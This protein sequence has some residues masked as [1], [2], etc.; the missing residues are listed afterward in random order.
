MS[1][2]SAGSLLRGKRVLI[3]A[4]ATR[5][6]LDPVR[7]LTNASTGRMGFALAEAARESGA[8]VTVVA[9][10]TDVPPPSGVRVVRVE[11]AR[12]MHRA[13]LK[14][15]GACDVF[16]GA[17]AV[18]DWAFSTTAPR[19]IKKSSRPLRVTLVPN[20]DIIADLGRRRRRSASLA[21]KVLVG[22]ALETDR[23]LHNAR[24]KL[25]RKGLDLVVANGPESMG[26]SSARVALVEPAGPP[27]LLP[28]SSKARAA[29]LILGRVARLVE[30]RRP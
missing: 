12:Q 7:F 30:E 19:K 21:R 11:S 5:E 15:F 20:P 18:S 23:R 9:G 10:P 17:A 16:I 6:R 27:R 29:R 13:V 24:E 8:R 4:G 1:N 3:T 22:F 2:V 28:L 14:A 25:A 26:G